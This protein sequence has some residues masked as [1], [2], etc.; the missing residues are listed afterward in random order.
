[1][2][3]RLKKLQ[4]TTEYV[5]GRIETQKNAK[6]KFEFVLQMV[7][8]KLLNQNRRVETLLFSTL[9]PLEIN[10]QNVPREDTALRRVVRNVARKISDS[11]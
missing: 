2:Q 8:K 5:K 11:Q 3:S 9:K 1:M 7:K 4:K 6:R 10:L